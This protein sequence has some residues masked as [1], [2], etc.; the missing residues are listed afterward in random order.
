MARGTLLVEL[1]TALP[2]HPIQLFSSAGVT[3]RPGDLTLRSDGARRIL[4][5]I[6]TGDGPVTAEIPLSGL[7]LSRTLR[8]RITWDGAAAVLWVGA[9]GFDYVIRHAALVAAPRPEASALAA[10]VASHTP[11]PEVAFVALSDRPEPVGPMPGLAAGTCVDTPSGPVPIEAIAPGDLVIAGG[12]DGPA[13][14][15]PV[16]DTL[17]QTLPARGTFRPV[18]LFAPY[19]GLRSDL[20]LNANQLLSLTGADVEYLFNREQ[21]LAL[22]AH[23]VS[24]RTG[25]IPEVGDTVTWHQ[26]LLPGQAS[27]RIGGCAVL[28]LGTGRLRRNP[29]AHAHSLLASVPR[30]ALPEP[31]VIAQQVLSEFEARTLLDQVSRGVS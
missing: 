17:C 30:R 21:V 23:L 15:V 14:P 26:L 12:T 6:E 11:V 25:R 31:P 8:I 10:R 4:I 16:V 7:D 9:P 5:R 20:I 18:R 1:Q 3:P 13:T 19:F 24:P 29:L 22:A 2:S 27:L 28:G